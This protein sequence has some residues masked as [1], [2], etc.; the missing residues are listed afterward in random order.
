ME[1]NNQNFNY[2][3]IKSYYACFDKKGNSYTPIFQSETDLTAVRMIEDAVSKKEGIIGQHP[4][5]FRL[6]RIMEM[7]M[8]DGKVKNEIVEIIECGV[9][10]NEKNSNRN[11]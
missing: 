8:R 3:I 6:D 1:K 4:K 9:Y 5:D 7:N 11:N 10:E 2:P